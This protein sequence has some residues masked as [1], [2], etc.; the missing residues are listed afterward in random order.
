VRPAEF[1]DFKTEPLLWG[2]SMK[3]VT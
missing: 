1:H 3:E 2:A